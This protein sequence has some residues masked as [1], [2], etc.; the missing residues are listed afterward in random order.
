MEVLMGRLRCGTMVWIAV[1][2]LCARMACAE[3]VQQAEHK[4]SFE[5]PKGW[6][7]GSNAVK[8]EAEAD[9]EFRLADR[10]TGV[11]I[12]LITYVKNP[13]ASGNPEGYAK[14]L[15]E[16]FAAEVPQGYTRT[17]VEAAYVPATRRVV[18]EMGLAKNG[19]EVLR[20]KGVNFVLPG[21]V[22][23]V[24]LTDNVANFSEHEPAFL[25]LVKS[26]KF[27]SLL[28]A[29]PEMAAVPVEVGRGTGVTSSAEART[30][31][32][33]L[34]GVVSGVFCCG[35]LVLVAA[36]VAAALIMRRRGDA[37]LDEHR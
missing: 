33:G 19:T 28:V 16:T 27:N 32:L 22:V 35:T 1:V 24:L 12:M 10:P 9:F 37:K 17:R 5:M 20:T 8:K 3:T 4:Y 13:L 25:E 6:E 7:F 23:M 14:E 2:F 29:V 30:A 11:P 26:L 15:K 31:N 21:E 34:A 36:A 18:W